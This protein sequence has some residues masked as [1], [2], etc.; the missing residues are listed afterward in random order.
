MFKK[1]AAFLAGAALMMA[2]S[3]AMAIS[4]SNGKLVTASGKTYSDSG[5]EA[6]YLTDIDGTEDSATAFLFLELAG[7]AGVNTLGIY[8]Y[9]QDSGAGTISLGEQLQVFAGS[10]SPFTSATLKF[11]V[12][13]GTVTNSSTSVTANIGTTFGFYIVSGNGQTYFS[14]SI[15]NNDG[16]HFL[17]YN[18]SDNT[19][20]DLFGSDVILG[21]EDLQ[22]LGD[23]DYDDMVVGVT[24][25]APVPEP[26]T[27]V[28]LGA[29]MLGLA[30]F[31]KRRMNR[32]A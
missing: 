5:A 24:D 21:I 26:G 18:T 19:E 22:G 3:S 17:I 1:L 9:T 14:H 28:L 8:G 25:V 29:G 13:G 10:A 15:L 23:K 30:I 20:G 2:T 4:I 32:E 6:V 12:A 16:D 31:G 27:M 7:Y 11:D